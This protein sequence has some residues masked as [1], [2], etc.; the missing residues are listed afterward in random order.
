MIWE[1]ETKDEGKL[2]ERL[3]S[4]LSSGMKRPEGDADRRCVK[5]GKG[6]ARAS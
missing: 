3:I 6:I 2:R 1:C 5:G 4:L